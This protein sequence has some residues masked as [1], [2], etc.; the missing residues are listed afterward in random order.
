MHLVFTAR[1]YA[2]AEYAIALCLSV[3][4]TNRSSTKTA[5]WIELIFGTGASFHLSYTVSYGNSG[6]SKNKGSSL[7]D[8]VQNVAL[9]KFRHGGPVIAVD[10]SVKTDDDRL[11]LL[12]HKQSR[13]T[14]V[15]IYTRRASLLGLASRG[16]SAT[17]DTNLSVYY[18]TTIKVG[19]SKTCICVVLV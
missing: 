4:V 7:W 9:R 11:C 2:S 10:K 14:S 1:C 18:Y 12:H 17:A 5:Q 16:P 19:L 6:N 15:A 8:F 3:S 13:V